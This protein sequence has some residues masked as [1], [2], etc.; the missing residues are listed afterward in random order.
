MITR[1]M[2]GDLQATQ[3]I[4][5]PLAYVQEQANLLTQNTNGVLM[6]GVRKGQFEKRMMLDL[7]IVVPNLNGYRYTVL[8]VIHNPVEIYPLTI[9]DHVN[10]D[11]C[12]CETEAVFLGKLEEILSSERVHKVVE[13]LYVQGKS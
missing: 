13:M 1:N 3:V 8:S 2:W 10:E 4:E 6:G 7:D 5:T 9:M 12:K 11:E